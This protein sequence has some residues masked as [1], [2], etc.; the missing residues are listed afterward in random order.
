MLD[1]GCATGLFLET[2]KRRGYEVFGV[3]ISEYAV[4]HMTES[5]GSQVFMGELKEA[6]F[7]DGFFDI[8]TMWDILEHLQD[9]VQVMRE[10]N[11]IL[12]RD[13]IIVIETVNTS[14]LNAK[15]LGARWPLYAP[16][17]HIFYFSVDTLSALLS[18]SGFHIFKVEPIQTYSPFHSHKAI[19]Y[20]DKSSV[21]RKALKRFFGDVLLVVARK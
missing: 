14:C 3:E 15:L 6:R 13:G 2:A 17:Y 19:R 12:R 1:V 20:F 8:I 9:P 11:R 4:R 16:P 18:K 5:I 10:A 7:S 21:I